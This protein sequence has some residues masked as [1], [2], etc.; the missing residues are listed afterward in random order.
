M[1]R[2]AAQH[3]AAQGGGRRHSFS[4]PRGREALDVSKLVEQQAPWLRAGRLDTNEAYKR[5]L[6]GLD[7]E[8]RQRILDRVPP[9]ALPH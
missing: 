7:P 2:V 6:D 1:E 9:D 5:V 3:Q 8:S 4:L